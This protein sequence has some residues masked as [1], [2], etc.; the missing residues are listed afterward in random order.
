MSKKFKLVEERDDDSVTGSIG[1]HTKVLLWLG[2]IVFL[3]I[4]IPVGFAIAGNILG[5]G[6]KEKRHDAL[7]GSPS[8]TVTLKAAQGQQMVPAYDDISVDATDIVMFHTGE[9]CMYMDGPIAANIDGKTLQV[10]SLRCGDNYVHV[11]AELVQK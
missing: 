5:N 4:A 1:R 7:Y 8:N 3:A 2:V 6:I 10:Y 11:N 9:I